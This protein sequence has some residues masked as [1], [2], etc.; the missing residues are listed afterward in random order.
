[1]QYRSV[2]NVAGDLSILGFGC[3]RLPMAADRRI[4]EAAASSMLRYAID[5]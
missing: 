3:M 2:R 4:D 1:M 5:H